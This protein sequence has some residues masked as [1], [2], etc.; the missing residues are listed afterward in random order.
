[1]QQA[2][3]AAAEEVAVRVSSLLTLYAHE[4]P[5]HSTAQQQVPEQVLLATPLVEAQVSVVRRQAWVRVSFALDE[6]RA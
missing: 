6:R 3:V 4:H 1:V 2:L 5:R